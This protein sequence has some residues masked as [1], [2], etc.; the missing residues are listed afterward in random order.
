MTVLSRTKLQGVIVSITIAWCGKDI[1]SSIVF[2]VHENPILGMLPVC[3]SGRLAYCQVNEWLGWFLEK[4]W[5]RQARGLPL[6]GLSR[7]QIY[8]GCS[9]R[10]SLQT[11]VTQDINDYLG[12][13][14]GENEPP[15]D[16]CSF[17]LPLF[18]SWASKEERDPKERKNSSEKAACTTYPMRSTRDRVKFDIGGKV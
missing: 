12:L 17:L 14:R 1:W 5:R 11:V 3:Q 13:G 15:K 7:L 6:F 2:R 9:E 4:G 16:A 10:G 18:L 8:T